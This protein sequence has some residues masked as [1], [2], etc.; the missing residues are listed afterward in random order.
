MVQKGVSHQAEEGHNI[1]QSIIEVNDMIDEKKKQR[2]EELYDDELGKLKREA[3][4]KTT[5]DK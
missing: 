1:K 4:C 5:N 3:C 2:N